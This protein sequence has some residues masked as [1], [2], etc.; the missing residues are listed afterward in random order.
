VFRLERLEPIH[1]RLQ[2]G[3]QRLD[4]SDERRG[5]GATL[6]RRVTVAA[7]PLPG[8]RAVLPDV[9][10]P[11]VRPGVLADQRGP[12]LGGRPV[13][14]R[15]NLTA[16]NDRGGFASRFERKSPASSTSAGV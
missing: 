12:P 13:G 4:G 6:A 11:S 8:D 5:G 10:Q 1:Q 9:E 14:A 16:G 15:P 7:S 2:I 3:D